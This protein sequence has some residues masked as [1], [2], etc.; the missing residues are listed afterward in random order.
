MRWQTEND[1]AAVL[2]HVL[3]VFKR[4]HE[5]GHLEVI[6]DDR[7]ARRGVHAGGKEG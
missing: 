3:Q 7:S 2:E 6:N 1:Q 5:V 4:F